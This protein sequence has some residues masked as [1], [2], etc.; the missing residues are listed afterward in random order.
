MMESTISTFMD[1]F[2]EKI[3]TN[4]KKIITRGLI[5]AVY[6][7]FGLTMASQAGL[8]ILNLI[9]YYISGYPTIVVGILQMIVVPW[10][11]GADQLIYDL[12]CMIGKKPKWMWMVWKIAWKFICP[13]VLIVIMLSSF[14]MPKS[15]FSLRGIPYPLYSRVIGWIITIVPISFIPILGIM[16]A[17]KYKFNWVSH[18]H[19]SFFYMSKIISFLYFLT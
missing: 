18:I 15:E 11:Y 13:G 3:N 9:D 7:G 2:H 19:S 6:F 14:F 4:K 5:C 16:Q 1:V 10:I 17:Y 8:Y 12:E